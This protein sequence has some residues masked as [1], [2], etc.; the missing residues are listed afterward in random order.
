[1]CTVFGYR[2]RLWD[3]NAACCVQ[4]NIKSE[5]H[6]QISGDFVEPVVLVSSTLVR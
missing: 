2:Q 5:Y 4:L 3:V 6:K 1:M